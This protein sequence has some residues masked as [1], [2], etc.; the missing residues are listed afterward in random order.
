MTRPLFLKTTVFWVCL[1]LVLPGCFSAKVPWDRPGRE[2]VH[3]VVQPGQTLYRI[4]K[5]YRIDIRHLMRVNGIR[6]PRNLQVG[7]RLWIPGAWRVVY[8]P[9]TDKSAQIPQKPGAQLRKRTRSARK[10]APVRPVRNYLSW[11]LKRG[12]VTS[13]FGRRNGRHH[14]GI[15]IGAPRG[16]PIRA[17][18]DGKVVFSGWGPTG[19]GLMVII[20]HPNH[21][22]TLYAHN[23]KNWVRKNAQVKKGQRIASVGSTGRSTGPHLHFEVRN[24]THPKNPLIYLPARR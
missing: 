6:D 20:K 16:T 12:A 1:A 7:R 23:S 21:L 4:A 24:D 3:H 2:G 14:D 22:T 13:T 11:P 9:P 18:A 15:D 10:P 8:V 17:A 5:A 19:Y